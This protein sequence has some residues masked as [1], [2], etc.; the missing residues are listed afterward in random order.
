MKEE[1]FASEPVGI[2]I[3]TSVWI[4]IHFNMK[5]RCLETV[6]D[7]VRCGDLEV[8][9][10]EILKGEFLKHC[11]K[12]LDEDKAS[13]R[14]IRILPLYVGD[15]VQ[16]LIDSTS[17]V[18]SEIVWESFSKMLDLKDISCDVD[19]R[20]IFK[21]YFDQTYPFS[22]G[23]KKAEFPDAFNLEI[24]RQLNN[25]KII[26][27]AGDGDY[28]SFEGEREG[29]KVYRNINDFVDEYLSL[30]DPEFVARCRKAFDDQEV[31]IIR[32]LESAYCSTEYFDIS[33]AHSELEDVKG[34]V[35]E[36]KKK[37]ILC[38][39]K[40]EG[41]AVFKIWIEGE[42]ELDLYCPIYV[43]D[44]IDKDDVFLGANRKSARVPFELEAT[45]TILLDVP[46]DDIDFVIEETKI[47]SRSFDVPREW[48]LFPDYSEAPEEE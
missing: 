2:L 17:A 36:I 8:L 45:M 31:E 32:E 14:K 4:S 19:W 20:K 34:L 43:Y 44:S 11:E 25:R 29:I 6:K 10:T 39:D 26:L 28:S 38:F 7:G 23:K 30:R 46:D 27:I 1:W 3:D 15:K 18:N 33:C 22:S 41:F 35:M 5:N 37:D 47:Y 9:T 48:T 40:D 16:E 42:V 24:L 12:Q 13:L 21:R